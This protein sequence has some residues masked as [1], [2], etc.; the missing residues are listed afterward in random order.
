VDDI[1]T[2]QGG[3][4]EV[5]RRRSPRVLDSAARAREEGLTLARPQ[6]IIDRFRVEK[7]SHRQLIL[8]NGCLLR[9]GLISEHLSAAEEIIVCLGTIGKF[10]E[11]RVA[12]LM[13][14]RLEDAYS[15]DSFGSL[16]VEAICTQACAYLENIARSE[17]TGMS[18]AISPGYDNWPLTDGQSQIF[19]MINPAEI[20]VSLTP[21]M[22]MI[23]RKSASFVVG[24]GKNISKKGDHCDFCNLKETC[25]FRKGKKAAPKMGMSQEKSDE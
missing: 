20:D 8:E 22:M 14:I 15:L 10:L 25:Q 7:F 3:N 18:S 24:L 12:E 19:A 21:S 5:I 13:E 1:L 4:P 2:A 16:A 11:G 6:F 17:G 9:G 23:P